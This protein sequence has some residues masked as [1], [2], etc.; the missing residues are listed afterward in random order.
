MSG[1]QG[2][3]PRKVHFQEAIQIKHAAYD[4]L[5]P[6]CKSK[7]SFQGMAQEYRRGRCA[8]CK[9]TDN[10]DHEIQKVQTKF[11]LHT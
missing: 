7:I 1:A 9:S 6:I 10:E 8:C 3:N 4:H 11:K 5:Q 2:K